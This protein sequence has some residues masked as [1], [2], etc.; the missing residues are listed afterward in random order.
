MGTSK[1]YITPTTIH[2]KQAKL[3]VNSY[4]NNRDE[5]SR[6]VAASKFARA[7]HRDIASS[8]AFVNSAGK[9]LNFAKAISRSGL[10]NALHKFNRSDLIG[11]T[12]EE[13]FNELLN[14]FTNQGST[15]EDYLSAGA[16]S[17]ALKELN[18]SE[19]EELKDIAPDVL[20]KEMLIE[21]IK[22]SFAFRYQEKI[23]TKKSP[24]QAKQII[25]EMNKYIST[26]LHDELELQDLK[27][28]DFNEMQTSQIVK[29]ALEDAYQ[30]F[31]MFYGE[32]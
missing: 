23:E 9:F 1:G 27:N 2:W 28:T 15:S 12:S 17:S 31:E 21:Y 11:K 6:V 5:S 22:L 14:E 25:L 19:I 18:I 3:A 29:S 16:I 8:T 7:M 32:E 10:N 13:I 30:V 24:A 20:L 26:K 4:V